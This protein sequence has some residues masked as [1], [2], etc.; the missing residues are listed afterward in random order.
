MSSSFKHQFNAADLDNGS[1]KAKQ[2]TTSAGANSA[3]CSIFDLEG[4][5]QNED[6]W[7]DTL[8]PLLDPIDLIRLVYTSRASRRVSATALN[9]LEMNSIQTRAHADMFRSFLRRPRITESNQVWE[10][11]IQPSGEPN[12][13]GPLRLNKIAAFAADIEKRIVVLRYERSY[14]K[15]ES[16]VVYFDDTGAFVGCYEFSS[17]Q[18]YED[19]ATKQIMLGERRCFN[20]D[21]ASNTS[22]PKIV[23]RGAGCCRAFP[24]ACAADAKW[25]KLR[26]FQT[27]YYW[28]E[29]WLGDVVIPHIALID[30]FAGTL[31]PTE[32][33][34]VLM[35]ALSSDTRVI[36]VMTV[37]FFDNFHHD[38]DYGFLDDS[39]HAFRQWLLEWRHSLS[40]HLTNSLLHAEN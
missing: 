31:S 17:E 4:L 32:V 11:L 1:K 14:D 10:E 33:I 15:E 16:L 6:I 2:Y 26:R 9:K 35:H 19:Y 22:M 8:R 38:F 29:G 30:S 13:A 28:Q 39:H 12:I 36:Y 5:L 7:R 24:S 34:F 27:E 21:G 25:R 40:R 23:L 37:S 3:T 18:F 20:S